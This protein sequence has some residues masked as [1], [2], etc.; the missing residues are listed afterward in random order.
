MRQST[1]TT[2]EGTTRTDEETSTDT[3]TDGNHV[4]MARL[5]RLVEL[6][7]TGR[8]ATEGLQVQTIAGH[9]V[10][11]LAPVLAMVGFVGGSRV[12]DRT[13]SHMLLVGFKAFVRH[14]GMSGLSKE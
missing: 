9:E 10:L 6:D 11:L 8:A 2:A 4:E 3:A 1:H 7:L 12:V 14:Y 5:H 13:A